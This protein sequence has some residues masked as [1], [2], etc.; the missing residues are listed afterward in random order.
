MSFQSTSAAHRL[1]WALA[2]ITLALLSACGGGGSDE[3]SSATS[4]S[5]DDGI[6]HAQAVVPATFRH[7][8]IFLTQTRLDNF[9]AVLN[10]TNPSV[11][12]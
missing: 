2:P 7:P 9:K 3:D 1:R 6:R 10:S 8:G 4:A 5:S 12:K 11:M